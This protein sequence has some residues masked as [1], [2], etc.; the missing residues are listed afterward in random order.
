MLLLV[1]PVTIRSWDTIVPPHK[2]EEV[3]TRTK[4]EDSCESTRNPP[5]IPCVVDMR[6][7]AVRSNG[8]IPKKSNPL[9]RFGIV[10]K[11]SREIVFSFKN[12]YPSINVKLQIIKN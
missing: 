2:R 9:M 6:D 10:Y 4:N 5:M 12:P 1:F 3:S 7:K 8:E 11:L